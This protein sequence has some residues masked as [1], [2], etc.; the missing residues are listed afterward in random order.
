M[1]TLLNKKSTHLPLSSPSSSSWPPQSG[2]HH[3]LHRSS[4]LQLLSYRPLWSQTRIYLPLT[5]LWLMMGWS[6]SKCAAQRRISFQPV[7]RDLSS[8]CL[9][10]SYVIIHR[11][12]RPPASSLPPPH[13]QII[14]GGYRGQ[15]VISSLSVQG[16]MRLG[17]STN[18]HHEH[19]SVS[20]WVSNERTGLQ[21]CFQWMNGWVWSSG[22]RAALDYHHGWWWRFPSVTTLPSLCNEAAAAEAASMWGITL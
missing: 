9:C 10:W 5:T 22:S 1:M 19:Q 6:N 7:E 12:P 11:H 21:Y 13:K 14:T 4:I 17:S 3:L 8:A 16:L 20:Q 2:S 18:N 15:K